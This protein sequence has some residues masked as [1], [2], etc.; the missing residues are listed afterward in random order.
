MRPGGA[1]RPALAAALWACAP[2]DAVPEQRSHALREGTVTSDTRWDAVVYVQAEENC[3][4]T[5]IAPNVVVTAAHCV[6]TSRSKTFECGPLGQIIETGTGN[7]LQDV[8]APEAIAIYASA[9]DL[10]PRARAREVITPPLSLVG[11]ANDIAFLVLESA[12][13][14][15]TPIALELG[16]VPEPEERVELF[17]FGQRDARSA[18]ELKNQTSA[19][20]SAIGTP[21]GMIDEEHTYPG[22]VQL[23]AGLC[24]GDSG[25]PVVSLASGSVVAVLSNRAASLDC[26]LPDSVSYATL[27]STHRELAALALRRAGADLPGPSRGAGCALASGA[28]AAPACFALLGALAFIRKTRSFRRRAAGT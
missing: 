16:S 8:L 21:Q 4:G 6:A 27:V 5:L 9:N 18:Q 11:C 19:E 7:R 13:E 10:G 23:R 25:G 15:V 14:G 26:L 22:T 3:T 1:L 2:P 24:D 20:V 28:H 12:I 17:G